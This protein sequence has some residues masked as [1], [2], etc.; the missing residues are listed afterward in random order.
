LCWLGHLV[1]YSRLRPTLECEFQHLDWMSSSSIGSYGTRPEA[2]EHRHPRRLAVRSL[3]IKAPSRPPVSHPHVIDAG[4]R[5]LRSLR[6]SSRPYDATRVLTSLSS[7]PRRSCSRLIG[8]RAR[9]VLLMVSEVVRLSS[10]SSCAAATCSASHT[11]P[12][13]HPR[14][15]ATFRFGLGPRLRRHHRALHGPYSDVL[16]PVHGVAEIPE[17]FEIDNNTTASLWLPPRPGASK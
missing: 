14:A 4:D 13:I 3:D 7:A 11:C 15:A 1:R 9:C 8:I 17:G 6:W 12:P 5:F 16:A 2:Q 10:P